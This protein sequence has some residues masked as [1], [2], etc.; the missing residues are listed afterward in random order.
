MTAAVMQAV[1]AFPAAVA[2]QAEVA[3][4]KKGDPRDA[5]KAAVFLRDLAGTLLGPAPKKQA[6]APGEAVP[7]EASETTVTVSFKP[8]FATKKVDVSTQVAQPPRVI[9][10]SLTK[11][12]EP[13]EP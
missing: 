12:P 5:N 9:E 3:L 13:D 1:N 6:T 4:G 11:E 7:P 10:G 2:Y 8:N